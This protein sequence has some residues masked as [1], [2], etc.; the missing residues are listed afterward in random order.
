MLAYNAQELILEPYAGLVFGFSLGRSTQLAGFQ[1]GGV[2]VGMVL[3]GL[4][5]TLLRGDRTLLMKR[6]TLLGCC[7]SA[8]ALIGLA[9]AGFS[10]ERWPLPPT[11]FALGFANGIFAVSALGLMMSFAGAGRDAQEGVRMGVWGAAQAM[12]FGIGGF[13]GAGA[14]DVMRTLLPSLPSAFASVFAAEAVCFLLAAA[15]ALRLD[16]DRSPDSA[17]ATANLASL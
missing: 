17:P 15:I 11:V 8:L 12:A 1:H 9:A 4:G 6:G 5:G 10:P 3:V 7:A 2:L 14:L 13:T 16:R